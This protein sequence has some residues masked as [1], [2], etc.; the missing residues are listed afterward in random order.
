MDLHKWSIYLFRSIWMKSIWP[1]KVLNVSKDLFLSHCHWFFWMS[2]FWI[3]SE[4]R[5]HLSSPKLLIIFSLMKLVFLIILSSYFFKYSWSKFASIPKLSR[6]FTLPLMEGR[7]HTGSISTWQQSCLRIRR[8]SPPPDTGRFVSQPLPGRDPRAPS[9]GA[10]ASGIFSTTALSSRGSSWPVNER[11]GHSCPSHGLC[12]TL[13]WPAGSAPDLTNHR[14]ETEKT[15]H[16]LQ[17]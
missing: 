3:L 4:W 13:D 12:P 14:K 1:S 7:E 2:G 16:A 10:R 8:L 17:P 6:L 15:M 9:K 11:R 5:A